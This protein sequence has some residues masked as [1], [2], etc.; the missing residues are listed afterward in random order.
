MKQFIKKGLSDPITNGGL[1]DVLLLWLWSVCENLFGLGDDTTISR[2]IGIGIGLQD[3]LYNLFSIDRTLL[4][5]TSFFVTHS[6]LS[7]D[8]H[9]FRR[10]VA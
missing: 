3:D 8:G 4:I 6:I 9:I 1:D 5:S 2:S 10:G 7:D